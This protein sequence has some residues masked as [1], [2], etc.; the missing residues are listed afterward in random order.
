MS[1]GVQVSVA[2]RI[3]GDSFEVKLGLCVWE[4]PARQIVFGLPG[5][6]LRFATFY[7]KRRSEDERVRERNH[8]AGDGRCT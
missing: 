4:T 6:F 5:T 1:A 2:R 7:G 3:G 8:W